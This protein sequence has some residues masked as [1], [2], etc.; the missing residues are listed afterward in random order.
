MPFPPPIHGCAVSSPTPI[1]STPIA[2]RDGRNRPISSSASSTP[3]RASMP[4]KTPVLATYDSGDFL[5]NMELAIAQSDWKGFE[6]RRAE[7]RKRGKLRGI[8]MSYYME[9]TAAGA[10]AAEIRFEP[11]GNVFLGI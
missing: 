7:A 11:N 8:G 9:V 4:W 10:E 6:A 2:A 3:P 1:G 5:A